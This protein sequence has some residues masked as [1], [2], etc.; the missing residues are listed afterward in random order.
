MK[1]SEMTKEQLVSYKNEIKAE[2]DAFKARGLKLDMSRGKPCSE[3]LDLTM[4]M[5]DTINSESDILSEN[6]T[7]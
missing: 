6:G 3:Q 5:L 7:D 2:Y 4:P 1:L